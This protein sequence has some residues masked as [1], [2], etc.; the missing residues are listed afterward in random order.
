MFRHVRQD[1]AHD[2]PVDTV[3]AGKPHPFQHGDAM[4]FVQVTEPRGGLGA[5]DARE[6]AV[7]HLDQGD[8]E[9]LLAADGRRLQPD[10]PAADDQGAA[11]FAR[12]RAPS[13]RR[14]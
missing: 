12:S 13:R 14:P 3:Q 11:V 10:I 7:G 2:L 4:A 9:A 5:G 8:V 1:R 6:D